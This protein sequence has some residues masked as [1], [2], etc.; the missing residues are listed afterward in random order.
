M[1]R[2]RRVAA[3]RASAA[4]LFRP[5]L[6]HRCSESE[7]GL[8]MI[9]SGSGSSAFCADI[10]RCSTPSG[11]PGAQST[12]SLAP[13]PHQPHDAPPF[14]SARR[15]WETCVPL[16]GRVP[17]RDAFVGAVPRFCRA[18]ARPYDGP[19]NFKMDHFWRQIG[20]KSS[21]A[22]LEIGT[23]RRAACSRPSTAR[24][25]LQAWRS[26]LRRLAYRCP[27]YTLRTAVVRSPFSGNRTSISSTSG[28]S[29]NFCRRRPLPLSPCLRTVRTPAEDRYGMQA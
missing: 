27:C 8:P 16:R 11:A 17:T 1:A 6:G 10:A 2:L 4:A 22:R 15:R 25:P 21:Q 28:R 7:R 12:A 3:G 20:R 23:G 24:W 29:R 5:G 9:S 18:P 13:L 14:V 19:K 26:G